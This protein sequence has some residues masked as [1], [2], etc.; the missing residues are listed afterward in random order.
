MLYRFA[1]AA[2]RSDGERDGEIERPLPDVPDGESASSSA[3]SPLS[4]AAR[5]PLY[6][7]SPSVAPHPGAGAWSP[8]YSSGRPFP[9]VP[10]VPDV[11][12]GDGASKVPC[13]SWGVALHGAW[14]AS[15]SEELGA[16]ADGKPDAFSVRDVTGDAAERGR[17]CAILLEGETREEPAD[18]GW[19]TGCED[20]A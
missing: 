19:W 4:F 1:I 3:R 18:R 5:S 16:C 6:F 13:G 14:G 12:D 15:R 20:P 2:V 11:P 9:H 10:D 7:S 17:P 8:L